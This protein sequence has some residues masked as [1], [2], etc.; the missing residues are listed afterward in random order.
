MRLLWWGEGIKSL[1]ES[2]WVELKDT[3]MVGR[4]LVTEY[5][6]VYEKR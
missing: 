1:N 5:D 3:K 4:D 6:V 2:I